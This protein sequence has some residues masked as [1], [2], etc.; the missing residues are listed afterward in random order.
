[1]TLRLATSSDDRIDTSLAVRGTVSALH[2]SAGRIAG[3]AGRHWTT[4]TAE[5]EAETLALEAAE[6]ALRL[7][8][9]I[10]A[11]RDGRN[12]D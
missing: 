2:A 5:T 9:L 11:Q 6:T 3:L 7:V 1:M 4:P 8:R 10:R 12:G